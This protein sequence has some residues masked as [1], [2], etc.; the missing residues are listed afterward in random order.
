MTKKILLLTLLFSLAYPPALAD[1]AVPLDKD[2][3]A[4]FAGVLMDP[5]K[6]NSVKVG[7]QER[8]LFE[9]ITKSQA[10]SIDL[11]KSNNALNEDK[12]NKLLEQNDKLSESLRS[13]QS[14]NNWERIGLVVLGVVMTA[15]A[16]Y[17]IKQVAK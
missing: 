10:H 5:E 14:L 12:V 13:A 17:A 16:G 6:A 11:L 4:P 3:K 1:Q 15:A 7:L 9:E 2:Q 8:D